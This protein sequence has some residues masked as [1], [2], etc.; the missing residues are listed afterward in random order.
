M[1]LYFSL[2]QNSK[3]F[4]S[5]VHLILRFTRSSYITIHTSILYYNSY[6]HLILQFIRSSYITIHTFILYYHS[7]VHLI[8]IFIFLSSVSHLAFCIFHHFILQIN[9]SSLRNPSRLW[10]LLSSWLF[11]ILVSSWDKI[12]YLE[13]P[14]FYFISS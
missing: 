2:N 1:F 5:Y 6:V 8:F 9:L 7:Y 4:H 10:S 14:T 3:F 11:F 12:L 13:C